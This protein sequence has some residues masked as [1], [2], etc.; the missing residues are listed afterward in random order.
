MKIRKSRIKILKKR[1]VL[2]RDKILILQ[3]MKRGEYYEKRRKLK[4]YLKY[5]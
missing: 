1:G 4:E 2:E 5:I 3:T